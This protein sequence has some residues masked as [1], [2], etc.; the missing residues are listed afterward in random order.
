MIQA[1]EM[2]WDI[3]QEKKSGNRTS[4]SF[5]NNKFSVINRDANEPSLGVLNV[6]TQF[7]F[8]LHTNK[9]VKLTR[10]STKTDT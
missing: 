7:H 2:Q 6:Q 10:G 9:G 4:H 8:E 5:E 1:S 3:Q